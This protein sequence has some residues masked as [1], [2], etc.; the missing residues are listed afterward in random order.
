MFCLFDFDLGRVRLASRVTIS[1]SDRCPSPYD[2]TRASLGSSRTTVD[3]RTSRKW[4][5]GR[6]W[7]KKG[8]RKKSIVFRPPAASATRPSS[9]RTINFLTRAVR[10]SS[11]T[12]NSHWKFLH[13]DPTV[14]S[15]HSA[16]IIIII[17]K[18]KI[19][20]LSF[21]HHCQPPIDCDRDMPAYR[22]TVQ[23]QQ[24]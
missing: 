16:I 15:I 20:R 14:D 17:V 5:G 22:S 13:L 1:Q 8:K 3:G 4:W 12:T 23:Q 6:Y 21:H 10:Y 18:E 19:G 2:A 7:M 9:R 11:R 24:Q